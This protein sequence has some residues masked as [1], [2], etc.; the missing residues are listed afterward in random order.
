M[1]ACMHACMHA[2]I[3]TYIHTYIYIYIIERERD[4]DIDLDLDLDLD[5]DID[6]DIYIYIYTRICHNKNPW[7]FQRQDVS[8]CDRLPGCRMSSKKSRSNTWHVGVKTCLRLWKC[9]NTHAGHADALSSYQLTCVALIKG[10]LV[11]YT[12][13]YIYI[14][15]YI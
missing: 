12:Y 3:H 15:I 5:I 2:Y 10:G 8:G 1:L 9:R 7:H 4:I 14:Y 6:I 11:L 13:I